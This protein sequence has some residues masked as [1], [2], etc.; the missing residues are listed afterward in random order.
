MEKVKEATMPHQGENIR[1]FRTAKNIKQDA[2]AK[3]I[4][5]T[6]SGV[7]KLER[8][9]VIEDDLLMKSAN[10]LGVSIEVL[11][12]LDLQKTLDALGKNHI[13]IEKIEHCSG[14]IDSTTNINNNPLE[15][16]SEL[17]ERLLIAEKQLAKY[18]KEGKE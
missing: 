11:K 14:F 9:K 1:F 13:T 2:F 17:Y 5:M 15:K 12:E 16:L 10:I 8:R 6:Q 18:E 3:E 4:G 7:T